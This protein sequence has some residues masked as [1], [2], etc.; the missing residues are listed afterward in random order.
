MA[1]GR[2]R[3]AEIHGEEPR[4]LEQ[5]V[6]RS[7]GRRPY[8]LLGAGCALLA[9]GAAVGLVLAFSSTSAAAPT[10]AQ[11]F[12]R[13]AAICRLYGPKLDAIPPADIAEPANVIDAVSRALP[14]VKAQT[15]AVR[16]LKAPPELRAKLAQ[17]F[18]LH[19]RRIA[20]LEEALRAGR[21]LDL[22]ALGIA[23]VDFQLLGPETARLGSA[24]GMP[25]PPC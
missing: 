2:E 17:W 20:K 19:D 16:A 7:S 21:R 13:V 14:L 1:A 24:I 5:R 10:K 25:H 9:S 11:Y 6:V 23:Y 12:S 3:G 4:R 22:R 8:V 18:K 15:N